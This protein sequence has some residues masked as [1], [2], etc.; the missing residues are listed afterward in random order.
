MLKKGEKAVCNPLQGSTI[1][2]SRCLNTDSGLL[3]DQV[4]AGIGKRQI[5]EFFAAYLEAQRRQVRHDFSRTD[6]SRKD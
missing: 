1:A 2:K 3:L 6:S 5:E 4:M